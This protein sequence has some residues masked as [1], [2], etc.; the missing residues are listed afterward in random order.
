MDMIG[1]FFEPVNPCSLSSI[2]F[3]KDSDR[4]M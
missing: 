2:D 3:A 4:N 1:L